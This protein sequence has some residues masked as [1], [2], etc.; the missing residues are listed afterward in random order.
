MKERRRRVVLSLNKRRTDIDYDRML[1]E[2]DN[3]IKSFTV[4]QLE[5]LLRSSCRSVA[6]ELVQCLFDS[7]GKGLLTE[8]SCWLRSTATVKRNKG[9]SLAHIASHISG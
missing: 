4:H 5:D 2:R 6:A 3:V 8:L 1:L 9:S 7:R